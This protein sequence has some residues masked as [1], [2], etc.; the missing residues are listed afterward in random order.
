MKNE[1]E[2]HCEKCLAHGYWEGEHDCPPWMSA[3][4]KHHKKDM[5]DMEKGDCKYCDMNGAE[6]DIGHKLD[7]PFLTDKEI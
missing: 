3:L 2:K 6:S 4:V 5:K 7:C 1:L